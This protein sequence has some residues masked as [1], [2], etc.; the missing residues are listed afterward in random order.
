MVPSESQSAILGASQAP[1]SAAQH[2]SA[3]VES[4]FRSLGIDPMLAAALPELGVSRPSA[5][6]TAALPALLTGGNCAVQSYTGSGKTLSYLLPVL[7]LALRRAEEIAAEPR[8]PKRG[9]LPDVPVQALV[10]APSQEL[11]MQIMRVA[12]SLLPAD[13]RK[14]AVQQVIGGANPKRQAEALS[15]VPGPLL[16][17]GTPGRL[18]EMVRTGSLKL[19]KCPL[20]VMDEADQL[21]S[22]AFLEDM[23]HL[24]DHCGKRLD[25]RPAQP[26]DQPSTDAMAGVDAATAA[27]VAA[28]PFEGAS[29]RRQ[30]VLVS[31]TLTPSVLG[32]AAKW[33]PSPRFVSAGAVPAIVPGI[34]DADGG[35]VSLMSGS[36]APAAAGVA[37][38]AADGASDAT[39]PEWGWGVR[40][41]DGP[42]SPLAPRTRGSAGGV[43]AGQ[44]LV[45]TLPPQLQHF[46]LVAEPRHKV[47]MMRR[48][49]HALG[50]G[51]VLAFMNFQQRLADTQYKLE[52]RGI[53]AGALH[54]ELPRLAR[55]NLLNS[56]RRGKL[57][58][59]C[60]S[61]V[62]ARGLDVP[63]CDAVVN[64]ELPSS[65]AHYAHRAGRTGRLTAALAAEA[66]AEAAQQAADEAEAAAAEAA[67]AG[68][69]AA[70]SRA[71]KAAAQKAAAAVEEALE[72]A[73]AAGSVLT[74]VTPQERFIVD[75]LADQLGVPLLEAHVSHGQLRLGPPPAGYSFDRDAESDRTEQQ[76]AKDK[77]KDKSKRRDRGAEAST[78]GR[79]AAAPGK[80]DK[81][82]KGAKAG[83]AAAAAQEEAPKPK[84]LTDAERYNEIIVDEDDD[85]P[86]DEDDDELEGAAGRRRRQRGGSSSAAAAAAEDGW[87]DEDDN[88]DDDAADYEI[89]DED[90]EAFKRLRP[91]Q[92]RELAATGSAAAVGIALKGRRK[93]R[94]QLEPLPKSSTA[95]STASGKAGERAKSGNGAP[96]ARA[97]AG[98]AKDPAP[99]PRKA[100]SRSELMA[101]LRSEL[102]E[103][104]R[105]KEK[106]REANKAARGPRRR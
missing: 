30:T 95:S 63:A 20:M 57:R 101:E 16:V 59:L 68:G 99:A 15:A 67:A 92:V 81:G 36:G 28:L 2:S 49:I 82:A 37:G 21:L 100:V 26:A 27:A 56:F 71:A 23:N 90:L 7:T 89:V 58:V 70:P 73:Q 13:M 69:A 8:T 14:W 72:L 84:R 79:D 61:D 53:K 91:A 64:L 38:A 80:A 6:Q 34:S 43:Q 31:A 33:C 10:V 104:R 66:A 98:A 1:P 52:A 9:G 83:A 41:W 60:V 94:M 65:A 88:D 39:N 18:S 75:K 12:K 78:S 87:G 44:G 103:L 106:E 3:A 35:M 93:Q 5:I 4:P 86:L 19:H 51:R 48:A 22:S 97:G 62:A 76:P 42:A 105:E 85:I 46:Y 102:D 29:G 47:D 55:S 32:R 25:L 54:G 17:V 45:P 77:D 11:A 40:G 74:I 50:A 96:G 24:N